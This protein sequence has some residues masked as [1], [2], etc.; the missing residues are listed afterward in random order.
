M[1]KTGRIWKLTFKI[2]H[3]SLNILRFYCWAVAACFKDHFTKSAVPQCSSV[4]AEAQAHLQAAEPSQQPWH[5]AWRKSVNH[6][7]P[8]LMH[9]TLCLSQGSRQFQ[10]P[11][12]V[13]IIWKQKV[14]GSNRNKQVEVNKRGMRRKLQECFSRFL[15]LWASWGHLFSACITNLLNRI[16]PRH[17]KLH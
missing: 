2:A 13:A 12:H 9:R 10:K 3:T 16:L 4:R 15:A 5:V 14:P 17:F 7:Q 6:W 11:T 8:P 1:F